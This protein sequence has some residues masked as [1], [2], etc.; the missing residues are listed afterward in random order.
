MD[1]TTDLTT[2]ATETAIDGGTILE[3]KIARELPPVERAMPEWLLHNLEDD[4]PCGVPLDHPETVEEAYQRIRNNIWWEERE[5]MERAAEDGWYLCEREDDELS[6]LHVA[7]D[8]VT[9]LDLI[10]W[11]KRQRADAEEFWRVLTG[12]GCFLFVEHGSL[13]I[14]PV[15]IVPPGLLAAALSEPMRSQLEGMTDE[16]ERERRKY[17]TDL[18]ALP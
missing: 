17:E 5:A 14:E 6:A 2:A 1:G 18:P 13:R 8:V 4:W 10:E 9:V 7:N 12:M 15:H 11:R 16:P 3:A